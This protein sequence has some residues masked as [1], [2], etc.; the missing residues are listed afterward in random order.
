[1]NND[2]AVLFPETDKGV[3]S[4]SVKLDM[5]RRLAGNRAERFD[6]L[7]TLLVDHM[8]HVAFGAE[9]HICKKIAGILMASHEEI[10]T[11]GLD[12]I[13]HFPGV[14]INS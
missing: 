14:H 6:D 8:H 11:F 1:M 4:V 10:G 12:P 2:R 3:L 5:R 13:D 9:E 7:Q